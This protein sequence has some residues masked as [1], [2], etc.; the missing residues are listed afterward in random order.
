[1]F[2][3]LFNII[4]CGVLIAGL[5]V[6]N[7]L[8]DRV[9][10]IVL[11]VIL[12]FNSI[13][14]F[15]AII[16]KKATEQKIIILKEILKSF[17]VSS[18]K[19]TINDN[20]KLIVDEVSKVKQKMLAL[21]NYNEYLQETL[22]SCAKDLKNINKILSHT[23]ANNIDYVRGLIDKHNEECVQNI[24][25]ITKTTIH[26][27]THYDNFDCDLNPSFKNA[28]VAILNDDD[29]ENFLLE[30][31]LKQY[32]INVSIFNKIDDFS[33][34]AC[35]IVDEKYDYQADNA[36]ILSNIFSK[37]NY[38]KRPFDKIKLKNMLI[39]ILNE[40]KVEVSLSSYANDVLVFLDTDVQSNY[41]FHIANKHAKLNKQVDSISAFKEEL[42]KNYKIIA[43][44]YH[45]ILYD[46]ET[47]K[48]KINTV[49][50]QNPNTFV[51]L[52]LGENNT[53]KNIDFV[54]LTIKDATEAQISEV[55]KKHT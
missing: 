29:L 3:S 1:M 21:Q 44:G 33:S 51:M 39:Q 37:Q 20:L 40:Y 36:I 5:Y 27:E 53:K 31:I 43:I 13:G 17:G 34:F 28:K 14:F 8:S 47:I 23:N 16:R 18:E 9:F 41:L 49:K 4:L 54:D 50:S 30:T 38:L 19:L 48:S 42:N 32:D 22:L 12:L 25:S 26:Y 24:Y 6:Q 2:P 35:V 11:I 7:L 52:F 45:C 10:T 15:A 55:I 46:Y